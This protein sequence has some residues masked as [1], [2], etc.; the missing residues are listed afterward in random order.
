MLAQHR[1]ASVTHKHRNEIW[2][3]FQACRP[4]SSL[5]KGNK[6]ESTDVLA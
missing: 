3:A 5:C 1:F 2:E 4:W 6:T